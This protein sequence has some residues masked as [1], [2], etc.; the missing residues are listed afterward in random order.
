[1]S[2]SLQSTL[3]SIRSKNAGPFTVCF[4]LFFKGPDEYDDVV[5][6]KVITAESVAALYD[7]DPSDVGVSNFAP[8]SAI[9]VAIPRLVPGGAPGDRDVAGGQQWVPLLAITLE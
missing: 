2:R 7:L 4:D 3:A 1:M 8:A 9:K 6:Q 5:A